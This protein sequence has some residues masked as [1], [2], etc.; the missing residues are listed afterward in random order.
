MHLLTILIIKKNEVRH[1]DGQLLTPQLSPSN[2]GP[3]TPSSTLRV[4]RD[5]SPGWLVACLLHHFMPSS[6]HY[7]HTSR[8]DNHSRSSGSHSSIGGNRDGSRGRGRDGSSSSSNSSSGSGNSSSSS[9]GSGNSSSSSSSG[10]GRGSAN[11]KGRQAGILC[12]SSYG[13]IAAVNTLKVCADTSAALKIVFLE[14][15]IHAVRNCCQPIAL[16]LP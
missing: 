4:P 7:Q 10:N 15:G 8:P 16:A 14:L 5:S 1:R 9:S 13:P 3:I 11:D 12:L 6:S 2:A